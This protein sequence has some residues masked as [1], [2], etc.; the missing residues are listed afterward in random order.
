MNN[1]INE[2]RKI[3]KLETRVEELIAKS[4]ALEDIYNV[5]LELARPDSSYIS[6]TATINKV[7]RFS[8]SSND[9]FVEEQATYLI[10]YL[11]DFKQDTLN[12]E[13]THALKTLQEAFELLNITCT[14]LDIFLKDLESLI[15]AT[16]YNIA[17][18]QQIEE[19]NFT[20]Q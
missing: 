13:F 20:I 16:H 18:E 5:L 12:L 1:K 8:A 3:F 19:G 4:Q 15:I 14:G 17:M 11:E 6:A 2:P 9:T 7:R 10:R